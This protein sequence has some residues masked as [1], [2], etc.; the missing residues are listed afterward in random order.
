MDTADFGRLLTGDARDPRRVLADVFATDAEPER[1][2]ITWAKARLGEAGVD[3]ASD[4]ISA[5][6][7]IREA[8]PRLGLKTS[9][10]LAHQVTQRA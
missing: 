3:A 2:A 7:T 10:Y 6:K 9:K 8:E 5:I 4:P 1:A